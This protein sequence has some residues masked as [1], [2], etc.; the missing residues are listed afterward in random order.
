M[1]LLILSGTDGQSFLTTDQKLVM[2]QGSLGFHSMELVSLMGEPMVQTSFLNETNQ[3]IA[4]ISLFLRLSAQNEV[5]F[6]GPVT[7]QNTVG[8]KA[9]GS[10]RFSLTE[11][12]DET[13]QKWVDHARQAP[14][15]LD[16]RVE[17]I[18]FE[19]GEKVSSFQTDSQLPRNNRAFFDVPP[20][21]LHRELPI[22]PEEAKR[23]RLQGFVL[24]RC[25]YAASGEVEDIEVVRGMLK[26]KYGLN[27]AAIDAV[28]KTRF[29]PGWKDGAPVDCPVTLKMDFY[30]D[31]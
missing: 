10:E 30:L 15:K 14:L 8:L 24:I 18:T 23:I 19:S 16:F 5:L 28:K 9:W 1:F 7:L 29:I 21:T 2:S 6:E 11:L 12:D 25:K 3:K 26:G 22:Y 31:K 20:I 17:S 4:A 27:Q 13:R